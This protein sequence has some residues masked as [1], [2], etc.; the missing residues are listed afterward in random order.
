MVAANLAAEPHG[1]WVEHLSSAALKAAIV[2]VVGYLAFA[3]RRRMPVALLAIVLGGL[4]ATAAQAYGD[5]YVADSIWRTTIDPG[6]P[7]NHDITTTSDLV[8]VVFGFVFALVAAITKSTRPRLAILAAVMVI[9]PPPFLWPLAGVL[10]VLLHA[11]LTG[12]S[13]PVTGAARS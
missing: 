10:T 3:L 13:L 7:G 1:H 2:A 9:I 8:V 6:P 5:W 12:R 11:Q 4:A